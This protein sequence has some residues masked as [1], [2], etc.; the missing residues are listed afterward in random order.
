MSI[1]ARERKIILF[2]L[3]N[4]GQ[5]T[6]ED[7]A[8]ALDVSSRTIHRDLKSI[9]KI[10]SNHQLEL[11]KKA[12]VG[13][14]IVGN[15]ADKQLLERMLSNINPIDYTQEERQAMVLSMLLESNEPVKLFTLAHE[16]DVT[17]ATVRNDLDQLEE[18]L[19]NFH[20]TIIRRRGYGVQIE[21]D[22][23]NKRSAITHLIA[24]Y[25]D[26]FSFI[27][28]LK[29][30]IQN[31]QTP[32]ISNRLL[33]LV[34]PDTL[35]IIE[36]TVGTASTELPYELADSARVGLVVHLALAI[37]R[38]KK[39]DTIQF[40]RAYFK[41][42]QGTEEYK[43]AEKIINELETALDIDIPE[44][45]IGYITMHL[46][47]AKLRADQHVLLEVENSGFAYQVKQL[48]A[49]ISK[50]L[51]VDMMGNNPLL[52]DLVTHLKPAIYRMQKQMKITN[53]MI[54]QIKHD[55]DDLFHLIA[56]A[57]S[58]IFPDLDFPDD[59]IGFLVLHFAAALLKGERQKALVI[60]SSGIGTAKILATQLMKQ[61]PEIKQIENKSMFD[62][63]EA[64]LDQYD[65][66][67]STLPL[68]ELEDTDYILVSPMLNQSEV[69]QIKKAIRQQRLIVNN[70]KQKSNANSLLQLESIKLYTDTILDL[71][72][73]F[74]I[75][76]RNHEESTLRAICIDLEKRKIIKNSETVFTKLLEREQAG[77]L[78]IPD[79]S[80]ALFHTRSRDVPSIHF[81][82]YVLEN[83]SPMRG[84][85]GKE[86]KVKH[87]LVMLAPED[88][89]Q[90]RLE[91]LS[92][93]SSLLIQEDEAVRLFESAD[94]TAIKFYLAERFQTFLKDKKLL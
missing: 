45:E 68:T 60:C 57:A 42:I 16:L 50:Q 49:Y 53:P 11:D 61:V 48:I 93:L 36:K 89:Q 63:D 62:V 58:V 66:I 34:N 19:G 76:E 86:M 6:V 7:I 55:Y 70:E 3:Q 94:E 41:Q 8:K 75:D 10:L 67:I 52:N 30:N 29:E 39:G 81:S 71:L 35:K 18:A 13:L 12:G 64:D 21:G 20:L 47:G 1:T 14:Q 38:L 25:V 92:Y 72:H 23:A 9:E 65:L 78:G 73:S 46:M 51:H 91:T 37:E 2:L 22:E 80:L 43:I 69:H 17:I 5:V 90:E 54:D 40:D 33:G 24:K 44:D 31:K 15:Q 85:D 74:Y 84:M 87:I 59:E 88:I 26:P 79:T 82:I 27:S 28:L 4:Q 77:G 83:A 32:T 56:E